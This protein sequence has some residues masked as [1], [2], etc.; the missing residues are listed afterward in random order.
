LP[1]FS[2]FNLIYGWNGSGKTALSELFRHLETKQPIDPS[3]GV[4]EFTVGGMAVHG[5]DI[6][7]AV[8]PQ[9][10]VFNRDSVDRTIFEVPSRQLPPVYY[11]GEDSVEMQKRVVALKGNLTTELADVAKWDHGT[12]RARR[13][14]EEF[15]TDQAR[16]IKDLLLISGGG[17]YRNYQAPRFKG[18]AEALIQA[19]E[20]VAP[21]SEDVRLR[22]LTTKDGTDKGRLEALAG[23][24]PDIA[25]LKRQAEALLERSVVSSTIADLVDDPAVGEWVGEGL[26]LHTGAHATDKCHFCD[27]SLPTGRLARLEA[28]FS[29]QLRQFVAAIDDATKALEEAAREIASLSPCDARLL[30]PHLQNDYG[31]ACKALTQQSRLDV[32]YLEA[33]RSALLTKRGDP[34]APREARLPLRRVDMPAEGAGP[35][36]AGDQ[37]LLDGESANGPPDGA[38]LSRVNELIEA[39][40]KHTGEFEREADAARTALENDRVVRALPDYRAKKK[41]IADAEAR[42]V[43]AKTA[44]GVIQSEIKQ[45]ELS[46]GQ[47]HRPAEE[48]NQEMAAY[49]GRNELRF[50]AKETGYTITRNGQPASNLSEGERSAIAFIYFLKSLQDMGFSANA[51]VIVIDDPVSSLDANSLYS[52][53]GLMRDRTSEAHQLFVLTHNF[54]FFR[55]VKGWFLHLRGDKKG[56]AQ[57]YMLEVQSRDGHRSSLI[58]PLDRLLRQYESEYHYLFKLVYEEAHRHLDTDTLAECYPAPN[59]ARRL[60]EAFLAFRVPQIHGENMFSKRLAQMRFQDGAEKH[61]IERFLNL[62]SHFDRVGDPEHDM[63]VLSETSAVLSDLLECMKRTDPDHYAGM[64]T[65]LGEE[66]S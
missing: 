41:A 10:R 17:P 40:N 54:T 13:D 21:L 14:F 34:F 46:I 25:T 61:R 56:Q 28:H 66:A 50:D 43:A 3:D 36:D 37:A 32:K 30:Y 52:A 42:C 29:D 26:A 62:G 53:F 31:R 27:Q 16:R 63:S 48:L 45:L 1:A 7:S 8:L 60:L 57:F 59:V 18:T 23:E 20:P 2:R 58:R 64:V 19:S 35:V 55:Q 11:L 49:L 12:S 33:L 6:A 5:G 15:C 22:H 4:V 44:A 38:T 24:Y 39:H 47:Y 9:V 65:A 51:G